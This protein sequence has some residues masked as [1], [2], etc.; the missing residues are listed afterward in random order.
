MDPRIVE[1]QQIVREIYGLVDRLET[2]FPGRPFTPDGHMVG[3]IGEVLA[4]AKYDLDL[5]PPG[6]PVHDAR[7][8]D[9]RLVQIKATQSDRIAFR[10]DLQP[11]H[12]IALLLNRDGTATGEYNGPG[13]EPWEAAGAKQSNG[14]RQ[15]SLFRLRQLMAAVPVVQQLPEVVAPIHEA[16]F[17]SPA[18]PIALPQIVICDVE[19]IVHQLVV[20]GERLVSQGRR[21]E[22]LN[23]RF[24]HHMF[25]WE[26]GRWYSQRG[27]NHWEN[28]LLAPECPTAEKFRRA[29][30]DRTDEQ[31]TQA[32]AIGVGRSGNLDFVIRSLPPIAV[33]W[34]GPDLYSPKELEEVFIKFLNESKDTIK[35]LAGIFTSS[36]TGIYGHTDAA[37]K[38]LMDSIDFGKRVMRLN[39]LADCNVHAFLAT[40]PDDGMKIIHWGPI[41][42]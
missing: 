36:T 21:G 6:T 16:Q 1:A 22:I 23:E 7:T 31:T 35:V 4:A 29:G 27:V 10:G 20:L 5:L 26:L 30:I 24:W 38:Y 8:I 42:C 9:G 14:Q 17:A 13:S 25:S 15:L 39:T 19:R 11:D 28:L 40:L 12:L 41:T 18:T 37:K 33:E 2:L 34:K 3:S 32:N